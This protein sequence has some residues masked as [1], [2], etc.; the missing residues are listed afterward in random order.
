MS[1]TLTLRTQYKEG[2]LFNVTCQGMKISQAIA[3]LKTV[4]S[5]TVLISQ[6]ILFRSGRSL[7]NTEQTGLLVPK[8]LRRHQQN[9][10]P[11]LG[12]GCGI[13][14]WLVLAS[15][16]QKRIPVVPVY[17]LPRFTKSGLWLL[18]TS[19]S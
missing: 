16:D 10:T 19:L 5:F 14:S 12:V 9:K 6:S 4:G 7:D 11:D 17:L 18:W 3:K 13:S 15:G 1:V 2:K 8:S